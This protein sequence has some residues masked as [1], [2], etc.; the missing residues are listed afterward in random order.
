MG[1]GLGCFRGTMHIFLLEGA[2][3]A[4]I[5]GVWHLAQLLH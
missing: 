4:L 5:Y 3:D 1:A 2:T